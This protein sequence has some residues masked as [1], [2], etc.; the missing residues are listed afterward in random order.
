VSAWRHRDRVLGRYKNSSATAVSPSFWTAA[1]GGTGASGPVGSRTV[2][3]GDRAFVLITLGSREARARGTRGGILAH[4]VPIAPVDG[5]SFQTRPR[6]SFALASRPRT[7]PLLLMSIAPSPR[8]QTF[9]LVCS[10]RDAASPS[11]GTAHRGT[12]PDD[13]SHPPHRPIVLGMPC[14]GTLHPPRL[15]QKCQARAEKRIRGLART[16]SDGARG[17]GQRRRSASGRIGIPTAHRARARGRCGRQ[18]HSL[19]YLSRY[20]SL[21]K[22]RDEDSGARADAERWG[23]GAWAASPLCK[24]TRTAHRTRASGAVRTSDAQTLWLS[25]KKSIRIK[26]TNASPKSFSKVPSQEKIERCEEKVYQEIKFKKSSQK[27]A[28]VPF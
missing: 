23:T 11:D 19:R 8:H 13:R 4:G 21:C 7:P 20:F 15:G 3:A 9:C 1:S 5:A 24:R 18:T 27:T 2:P 6:A 12:T 26:P 25:E 22:S 16:R 28:W 14:S 17:R 10:V